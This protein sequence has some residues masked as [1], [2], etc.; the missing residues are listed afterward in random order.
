MNPISAP[1]AENHISDFDPD[2]MGNL[3]ERRELLFHRI[4]SFE[5]A[6]LDSAG[7][8]HQVVNLE[9]AVDSDGLP[10]FDAVN[11]L[12]TGDNRP[13]P[14]DFTTN[15]NYY[16]AMPGVDPNRPVAGS[17]YWVP[18]IVWDGLIE[19]FSR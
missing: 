5:P 17:K 14:D 13:L 1:V 11:P 2:P 16:P 10:I 9:R 7:E 19:V 18:V 12:N 6:S 4:A 8:W 3:I 15:A